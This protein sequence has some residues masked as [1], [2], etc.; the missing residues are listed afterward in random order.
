MHDDIGSGRDH[1]LATDG[2]SQRRQVGENVPGAAQLERFVNRAATVHAERRRRLGLVEGAQR[3]AV[4]VAL[5]QGLEPRAK[6]I[7]G[8]RGTRCADVHTDLFERDADAVQIADRNR[9]DRET[10]T[11]QTLDGRSRRTA[12]PG[13]H[14][15]GLQAQ[16]GFEVDAERVADGAEEQ[17]GAVVPASLEA[18][19]TEVL[20]MQ[21]RALLIMLAGFALTTTGQL[22]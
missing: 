7:D 19:L 17:G 2:R 13:Q 9:L 5:A 10:E 14:Q 8:L 1:R 3:R 16:Q 21:W 6:I 18:L 15:V 20:R 11:T 12:V 4:T 22:L